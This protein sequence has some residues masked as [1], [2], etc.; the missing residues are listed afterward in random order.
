MTKKKR[1]K[2]KMTKLSKFKGFLHLQPIFYMLI[3]I[4]SYLWE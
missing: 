4:G 2:V 1:K 3:S